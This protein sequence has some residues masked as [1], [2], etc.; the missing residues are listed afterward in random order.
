M[1]LLDLHRDTVLFFT[2]SGRN[3]YY[4]PSSFLFNMPTKLSNN[5]ES[6]PFNHLTTIL[7]IFPSIPSNFNCTLNPSAAV[8]SS[9]SALCVAAAS[10]FCIL[11]R[12][13]RD[14]TFSFVNPIPVMRFL[15]KCHLI[16]RAVSA[17]SSFVQRSSMGMLVI[18]K[19]ESEGNGRRCLGNPVTPLATFCTSNSQRN[20]SNEKSKGGV[21]SPAEDQSKTT[22]PP[23]VSS[24]SPEQTQ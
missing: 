5:T 12:A 3:I 20:G 7:T 1:F 17:V 16:G 14:Q 21:P 19:V 22:Q 18:W 6:T 15:R 10:G 23:S 4:L 9:I 24:S 13:C 2:S 11:R 8:R